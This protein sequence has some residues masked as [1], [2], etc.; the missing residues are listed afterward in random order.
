LYIACIG[1]FVS[2]CQEN[3]PNGQIIATLP[4][5]Q[6]TLEELR[7][8]LRQNQN[9]DHQVALE[10]LIDRKILTAAALDQNLHLEKDFHFAVRK[11]RE[12]L[13]IQQL[14]KRAR[15]S[16]P[17]R[18]QEAVWIE[19]NREPWRYKDR[20]RLYFTRNDENGA[21]SVFW[22]DTAE[23]NDGLPEEII[24][25]VPGDIITMKGKDWNLHLRESL[26]ADPKTMFEAS[27]SKFENE[28]VSE[29]LKGVVAKVRNSGQIKYQDGY[30]PA[31]IK[32]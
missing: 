5:A 2:A 20:E 1:L 32:D 15:E 22:I 28:Y 17:A 14:S 12:E 31:A 3:Q 11:A 24:G 10:Q 25:A 6:I 4:D 9:L 30:G 21:R 27:I 8:E 16:V 29:N 7:Y 19:I 26:V 13:L 18:L 23:Y